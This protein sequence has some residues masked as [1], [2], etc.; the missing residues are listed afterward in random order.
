[1]INNTPINDPKVR[2]VLEGKKIVNI[3]AKAV[4]YVRFTFDDNTELEVYVEGFGH[5]LYGMVVSEI[6]SNT[7]NAA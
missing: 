6:E 1:M 5:G 7:T 2:S 4:N 3:E